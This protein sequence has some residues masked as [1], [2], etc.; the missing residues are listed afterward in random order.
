MLRYQHSY[1][2]VLFRCGGVCQHSE[3]G[4]LYHSIIVNIVWLWRPHETAW[5]PP[6]SQTTLWEPLSDRTD[7][8]I[9]KNM[10][11]VSHWDCLMFSFHRLIFLA[12]N[13]NL[14]TFRFPWHWIEVSQLLAN[15]CSSYVREFS[16]AKEDL[17]HN[18]LSSKGAVGESYDT[19]NS[20]LISK[21]LWVAHEWVCSG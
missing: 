11:T 1:P 20:V 6:E 12:L 19:R 13:V 10:S 21:S 16:Q 5:I 9:C 2:S 15:K 7:K 14:L 4:K 17:C 8:D 18:G 3:D